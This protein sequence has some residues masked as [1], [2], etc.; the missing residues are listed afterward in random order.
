MCASSKAMVLMTM[1][2]IFTERNSV[3]ENGL[4]FIVM[5]NDTS[6]EILIM[7]GGCGM[8]QISCLISLSYCVAISKL[9]FP[10]KRCETYLFGLHFLA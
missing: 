4:L 9:V 7:V 5:I 2:W 6:M 10:G 3:S 1:G 8:P